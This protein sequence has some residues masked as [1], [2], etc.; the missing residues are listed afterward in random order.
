MEGRYPPLTGP[1]QQQREATIEALVERVTGLARRQPVL[2]VFE[3][4]HWADPTTLELLDRLIA[5]IAGE[6]VV[7]LL[8][9]RSDIPHPGKATRTRRL[10]R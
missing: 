10:Y 3:D 8:T 5:R 9:S 1:P 2:S 4:L 7:V 6:R